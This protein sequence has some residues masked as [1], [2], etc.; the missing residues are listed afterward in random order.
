MLEVRRPRSVGGHDRPPVGHLARF[1]RARVHH[2]LDRDR[3]PGGELHT[4]LRLSIVRDL[5]LLVEFHADAM[6]HQVLYDTEARALDD[7]LHRG[8]DVP[9]MVAWLR[10][11]DARGES[12]L[13]DLEQ[14]SR[15]RGHLTHS[16]SRRGVRV[17][18]LVSYAD[19]ERD[20]V[21]FLQGATP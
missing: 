5:G 16:H 3:E 18:A 20:D 9:E 15:F 8:A 7:S 17:E 4:T 2:G 13:G 21:T 19:I 12:R 14:T 1:G 11:L 10:G 6:P